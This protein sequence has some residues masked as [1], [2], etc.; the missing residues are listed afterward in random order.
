[1]FTLPHATE[2]H[3]GVLTSAMHMAWVREVCG[4]LEYRHRYSSSIVY[5]NFMWPRN[6]NESEITDA[7]IH[8]LDTRNLHLE[9]NKNLAWL[10][11]PETMPNDLRIAHEMLDAAVDAAYGLVNPTN[12]E[13]FALLC[14]L[15][16]E[17]IK[18]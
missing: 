16:T 3:F 5:N 4:R 13:R 2:Y 15:Y 18:R 11:N 7:A 1:V 17:E 8:V 10:Y 9:N 6:R 14:K 12:D